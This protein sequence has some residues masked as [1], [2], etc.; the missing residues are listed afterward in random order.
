[1]SSEETS[2]T[3]RELKI[4]NSRL[5]GTTSVQDDHEDRI[6]ALEKENDELR[7]QVAELQ[8]TVDDLIELLDSSDGKEQ[9]VRDIVHFAVRKRET[10]DIIV[11]T[12][13]EVR[14]AANVSERYAYTLMNEDQLP[15]ERDWFI[16]GENIKQY[17]DLEID[18]ESQQ[19]R[20]GVDFEGVQG[21][22][23]PLRKFKNG[24]S[25]RGGEE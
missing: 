18:K 19:K 6:E 3:E 1:M 4:L 11:L 17:G 10:E 12:P 24:A 20:L 14:G 22:P 8:A 2:D 16:Y 5:D 15:A 21:N 23:V 25:G 9:K 13:D 7:E